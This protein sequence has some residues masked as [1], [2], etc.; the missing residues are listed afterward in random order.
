MK[1]FKLN[2]LDVQFDF[3]NQKYVSVYRSNDISG[4]HLRGLIIAS[5]SNGLNNY[6][7]VK[8]GMYNSIITSYNISLSSIYRLLILNEYKK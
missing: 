8:D 5:S 4:S 2:E 7:F 6:W 1:E 3:F